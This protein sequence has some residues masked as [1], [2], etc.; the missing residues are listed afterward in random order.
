MSDW[1]G[2][3]LIGLAALAIGMAVAVEMI[4]EHIARLEHQRARERLKTE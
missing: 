1:G 3:V 2:I 4:C